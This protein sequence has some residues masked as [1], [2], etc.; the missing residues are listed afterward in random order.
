MKDVIF[1]M[2]FV[3]VEEFGYVVIYYD[4]VFGEYVDGVFCYGVSEVVVEVVLVVCFDVWYV[5]VCLVQF[6]VVVVV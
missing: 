5:V 6:D 2:I 1:E 4:D 3:W